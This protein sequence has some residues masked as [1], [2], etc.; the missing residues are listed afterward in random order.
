MLSCTYKFVTC[1]VEVFMNSIYLRAFLCSNYES[2]HKLFQWAKSSLSNSMA[3]NFLL[4]SRKYKWAPNLEKCQPLFTNFHT[5]SLLILEACNINTKRKLQLFSW[6]DKTVLAPKLLLLEERTHL[7]M[8]NRFAF[9]YV[10]NHI[11]RCVFE[12][13][14]FLPQL[15]FWNAG[16]HGCGS[17]CLC[18][19]GV[20]T[21]E[22]KHTNLDNLH[23]IVV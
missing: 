3:S 21:P 19:V 2:L 7:L 11:W 1:I 14:L 16:R 12:F 15:V 20:F 8:S 18:C 13:C 6:T 17:F 5:E 9:S 4:H 23:T 10:N 22:L